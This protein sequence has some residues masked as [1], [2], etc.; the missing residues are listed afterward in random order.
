MVVQ[1]REHELRREPPGHPGWSLRNY[2]ALFMAVLLGVA[3]LAAC[4]VRTMAEVAARQ[5]ASADASFAARVAATQIFD[6]LALLDKSTAMLA[7]NR[8]VPGILASPVGACTLTF[9][10]GPFGTGHLD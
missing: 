2:M 4:A 7:A 1:E 8:Q 6:D 3:P 9:S 5:S 10:G